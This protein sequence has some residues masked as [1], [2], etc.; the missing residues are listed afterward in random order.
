MAEGKSRL[1]LGDVLVQTA[2]STYMASVAIWGSRGGT[3]VLRR[4]IDSALAGRHGVGSGTCA[5]VF[6]AAV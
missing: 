1:G 2:V 6:A 5:A 3:V 4:N